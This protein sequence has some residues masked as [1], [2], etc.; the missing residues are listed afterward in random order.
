MDDRT[1]RRLKEL[2]KKKRR[3][4]VFIIKCM[5][6]CAIM[7]VVL[8]MAHLITRSMEDNQQDTLAQNGNNGNSETNL[9][10]NGNSDGKEDTDNNGTEEPVVTPDPNLPEDPVERL[11]YLANKN[12]ISMEE[13]PERLIELLKKN[14]Q[15]EEFVINYP[16]K[17]E[18]VSDE[19]LAELIANPDEIP[20][21]FQ[22][23]MR[24]GYYE[25][26]G[27]VLGLTGCG[28]TC[29]SMVASYLFQDPNLTPV[30]MAKFST[31]NKYVIDG[32]GTTWAMMST[33]AQKLGLNVKEVPLH[34]NTVKQYLEEGHPIICNVGPGYFT[35]GG[36]YIVFTGWVDNMLMIHD[37]NNKEYSETLWKFSDIQDQIKNMWVYTR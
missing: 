32:G 34:M 21:L 5:L 2:Q 26:G 11:E 29:M 10:N 22:W 20:M 8:L 7:L 27:D 30:Y 3:Q 4:K 25:Y 36:H 28:A 13:Y 33:G 23:D 12:G 19:P 16:T 14:P 24:W 35:E 37:P 1:K 6:A 18:E 15:T 9:G 31:E 17:K